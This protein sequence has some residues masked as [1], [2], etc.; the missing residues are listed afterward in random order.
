MYL[1]DLIVFFCMQFFHLLCFGDVILQIPDSML[2][3][4]KS[5]KEQAGCLGELLAFI[6]YKTSAYTDIA[7][8]GIGYCFVVRNRTAG[9]S[10]W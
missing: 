5:L 9:V 3:G 8:I 6:L 4:L 7:R 2:V 10:V 1:Q